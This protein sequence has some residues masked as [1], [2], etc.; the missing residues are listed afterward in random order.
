M[1][2]SVIDKRHDTARFDGLEMNAAF[3]NMQ[4]CCDKV[5]EQLVVDM[6]YYNYS[7]KLSI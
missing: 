6:E 5:H 3:M 4:I 1:S 7:N 2:D